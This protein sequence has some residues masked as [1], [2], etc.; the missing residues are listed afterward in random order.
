MRA[1]DISSIIASDLAENLAF[2]NSHG[3]NVGECLVHPQLLE[4]QDGLDRGKVIPLWLV[5]TERRGDDV[6]YLVVY[7]EERDMFGLAMY[8]AGNPVFLGFHGS[9][10]ETLS[11][12]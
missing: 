10:T 7:S 2:F 11:G 8:S 5:L 6:G 4:F 3:V 1:E 9:F 12:M